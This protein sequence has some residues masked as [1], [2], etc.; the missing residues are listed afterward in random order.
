MKAINLGGTV[1]ATMS[2]DEASIISAALKFAVERD[3]STSTI[4]DRT[5]EMSALL[6]LCANRGDIIARK[7]ADVLSQSFDESGMRMIVELLAEQGGKP[8]VNSIAYALQDRADELADERRA[9]DA[10]RPESY[11]PDRETAIARH[12]AGADDPDPD[13]PQS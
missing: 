7:L 11:A 5:D 3:Y 2:A 10:I 12:M 1:H 8:V 4:I 13:L 9:Q 6:Y